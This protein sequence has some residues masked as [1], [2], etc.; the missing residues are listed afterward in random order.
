MIWCLVNV[1]LEGLANAGRADLLNLVGRIDIA[2]GH[3]ILALDVTALAGHL[4]LDVDR[5]D[6]GA[7]AN[8]VPFQLR[9]RGVETKL[10]LADAPVGRDDTLIRNI[11]RAHHWFNEIKA[12]QSFDEITEAEGTSRRRIQQMIDLAFLAPDIIRD[13]LDGKQPLGFTSDWCM[14]H[15]LPSDWSEQ[16]TML[17]AL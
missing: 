17:A 15:Q 12:G 14:R 11:A 1:G 8:S 6:A 5:L 7:L 2:P 16:R 10:V 3:L 4:T 13:V 9:K